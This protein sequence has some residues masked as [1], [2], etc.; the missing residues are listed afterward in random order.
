LKYSSR[1]TIPLEEHYATK[2]IAEKI[3][4]DMNTSDEAKQKKI[5]K[6]TQLDL[7]A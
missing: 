2:F 7:G 3:V 4:T 6:V 1:D 5:G